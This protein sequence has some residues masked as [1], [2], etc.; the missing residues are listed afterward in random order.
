[1]H[2]EHS[3]FTNG[4]LQPGTSAPDFTLHCTPDQTVTLSELR[5]RIVILL[6]YPAD[7]SPI[8]GSELA[9]YNELLPEFERRGVNLL[10][11]SVD[12]AWC[13]VAYAREN[14][15]KFPLLAD[16]EPKAAVARAYGV[17]RQGEGTAERAL[18]LIDPKGIIRWS[19]VSPVGIVPGADGIL[20]A[21]QSLTSQENRT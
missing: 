15:L 19:Y 7:W 20:V 13:H 10:G 11:I 4:H 9:L 1:V 2:E 8:C 5:G 6:F 3:Q 14:R 16:Y 17:Y 21:L 18:F 12:S